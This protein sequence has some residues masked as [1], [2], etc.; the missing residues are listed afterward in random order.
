MTPRDH[1]P[2]PPARSHARVT[3]HAITRAA[4]TPAPQ[5]QLRLL[6]DPALV[7]AD[8]SIKSLERRAAGLLALVA[9]EPG[10]TRARA[11]ALLWPDSD[12]ARQALRQQISRFK[13][14][15]AAELVRGEDALFL[16]DGVAVD[17]LADAAALLATCLARS[18]SMTAPTLPTG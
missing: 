5:A 18:A 1:P 15:Y 17:A 13:K 12:N 3:A 16:A 2:M 6:G 14:N 7:A 4:G 11:A 8:G 10:V 9:F